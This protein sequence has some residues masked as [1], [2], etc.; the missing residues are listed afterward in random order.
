MPLHIDWKIASTS[1]QNIQCCDIVSQYWTSACSVKSVRK[2]LSLPTGRDFSWPEKISSVATKAGE[3]HANGNNP[4]AF[5]INAGRFKLRKDKVYPTPSW[6]PMSQFN[7][8]TLY[9]DLQSIISRGSH[10][11][12]ADACKHQPV[13][14][15]RGCHRESLPLTPS[16]LAFHSLPV[17]RDF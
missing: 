7:M 9:S 16:F 4:R 3:S 1:P 14:K 5:L 6:V 13:E 8:R 17:M 12:K 15:A 10:R 11:W 2:S